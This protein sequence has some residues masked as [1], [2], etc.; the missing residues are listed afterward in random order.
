MNF[1]N[2]NGFNINYIEEKN[3]ATNDVLFIHGNLA[4]SEWWVP[5]IEQMRLSAKSDYSG[6]VVCADWRG[7]GRSKGLKTKGD[8]NFETY[9]EDYIR[10]IEDRGMK[11]VDV[12]GHST[13]G[14][15]AMMA[16]LKRPD[17]FRSCF[18]LDT[19]GPTGLNPEIP[20]D[21]V[22]A[23]FEKMS[24]DKDYAKMVM[25]AT[26]EGVDGESPM[27]KELFEIAWNCDKVCWTGVPD[28]LCND[29]DFSQEVEKNWSLPS[30][31][32]HG[33]KDVVLPLKDSQE[34]CE[35]LP[36]SQF[37]VL[38][39]QGHSCNVEN[40]KRFVGLLNEFWGSL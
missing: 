1:F 20:V 9:A 13:G 12:V 23:H 21:T 37:M 32:V 3:I 33:E 38:D 28:V 15:I 34:L 40:P 4:S 6:T 16:I 17:L 24:Q 2:S 7:Y 14:M 8:I 29:I 30:M 27:F 26:I 35:F 39:G 25:A 11:E 36:N 5:S 22:L 10:L 19:V 31:V 18:F